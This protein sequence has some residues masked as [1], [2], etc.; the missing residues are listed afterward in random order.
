[1]PFFV[2]GRLVSDARELF[3]LAVPQAPVRPQGWGRCRTD[4][5]AV[6]AAIVHGCAIERTLSRL[7]DCRRPHRLTPT[8]APRSFAP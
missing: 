6:P 8:W 4:D 5:R 2:V 3:Q 7:G 1:M